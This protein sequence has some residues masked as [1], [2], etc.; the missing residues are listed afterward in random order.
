MANFITR[1]FGGEGRDP[2]A[3][4][5]TL[6]RDAVDMSLKSEEDRRLKKDA[7]EEKEK[8]KE[9]QKMLRQLVQF[10]KRIEGASFPRGEAGRVFQL[11]TEATAEPV[12]VERNWD[13][14]EVMEE[15]KE[16]MVRQLIELSEGLIAETAVEA[17]LVKKNW[18]LQ[19]A[20]W[21]VLRTFR[22][23]ERMVRRLVKFG[24]GL[25][26]RERYTEGMAKAVLV[27][28]NWDLEEA[29]KKVAMKME[30]EAKVQQ[31]VQFCKGRRTLLKVTEGMAEAWLVKCNWNLKAAKVCFW[32]C[33]VF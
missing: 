27:E 23:R 12:L 9:K 7:F 15:E 13:L 28:T 33:D 17:G 1:R 19:D 25:E 20:R 22:Q 26:G 2:F 30:K 21:D 24:K 32:R 31:L 18:D 3:E 29:G 16:A 14:E 11:Y 4:F 6:L 5:D 8:E 10:S